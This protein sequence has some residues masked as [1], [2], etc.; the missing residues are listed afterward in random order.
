M[1]RVCVRID[2]QCGECVA[3]EMSRIVEPTEEVMLIKTTPINSY[4]FIAYLLTFSL[5][6]SKVHAANTIH[7]STIVSTALRSYARI[8]LTGFK[9]CDYYKSEWFGIR[10]LS[11]QNRVN[12]AQTD[13]KQKFINYSPIEHF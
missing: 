6:L 10:L 7:C 1:R 4:R 11:K 13:T 2:I 3:V 5:Y 8:H 9:I 12:R